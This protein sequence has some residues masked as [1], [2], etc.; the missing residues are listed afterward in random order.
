M[1][2]FLMV[3]MGRMSVREAWATGIGLNA[4]LT[5]GIIVAELLLDARLIDEHLFTAIVAAATFSTVIVPL[6]FTLMMRRWGEDLLAAPGTIE[7]KGGR[8]AG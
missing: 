3:P 6:V 2:V 8:Y 1:G 7:R 4:R 5:T